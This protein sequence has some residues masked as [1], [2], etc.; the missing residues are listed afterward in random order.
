MKVVFLHSQVVIAIAMVVSPVVETNLSSGVLLTPS[1]TL[2]FAP[3][4]IK[5]AIFPG[6]TPASISQLVPPFVASKI[7][8]LTICGWA[9]AG[10][11]T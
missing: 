11:S 4:S 6:T 10:C 9:N 2:G 7:D 3:F 1:T 8:Y 5:M